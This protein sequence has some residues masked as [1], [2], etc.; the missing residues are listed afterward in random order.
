MDVEVLMRAAIDEARSG[1]ARGQMPFGCAIAVGGEIIA[2]GH[3]SV[4][5]LTDITAHAD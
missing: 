3:N 1:I 5:A 2:R 4:W